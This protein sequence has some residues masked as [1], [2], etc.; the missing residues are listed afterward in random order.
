MMMRA[1]EGAGV[2]PG[3][4]EGTRPLV[5]VVVPVYNVTPAYVD[6]CLASIV[7]QTYDNV[8]VMLVNDGSTDEVTGHLRELAAADPRV[9]FVEQCN[10][11]PSRARNN[12]T[13]AAHGAYVTYVDADDELPPC[14][15]EHAMRLL[16]DGGYD[17]LFGYLHAVRR[18]DDKG[19]A[20]LY[21]DVAA[22][23][24]V[25][26]D[27]DDLMRLTL[28]GKSVS[29]LFGTQMAGVK[30]GP[31]A[32]YLSRDLALA[33]PFPESVVMGED[34]VWNLALLSRVARVAVA[35]ECWYWYRINGQSLVHAYRGDCADEAAA[36][37][38]E[39]YAT[40]GAE[41]IKRYERA[42]LGRVLGEVNRVARNYAMP[43]C[44]RT[45]REKMDAI[46]RIFAMPEVRDC[47]RLR[48]ALAAGPGTAAK[49]LMCRSGL[50]MLAYKVMR[51]VR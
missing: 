33:T 20:P 34:M 51:I 12:G 3:A 11:G 48:A 10:A 8:E 5:S 39:T 17:V 15:V 22:I 31:C 42:Y 19:N 4:D 27:V 1:Q 28:T 29:P 32:R 7:G 13:R 23:P 24:C 50:N 41:G 40:L 21:D 46:R 36:C 16:L 38:R 25:E 44:A 18:L 43:A 49:Y 30:V 47:V 26:A 9:R 35:Q 45:H 2:S 14:A 37:L 6:A